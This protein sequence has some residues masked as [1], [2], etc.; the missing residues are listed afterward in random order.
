MLRSEELAKAI[1]TLKQKIA[2]K[3]NDLSRFKKDEWRTRSD[4]H[5]SEAVLCLE[6]ILESTEMLSN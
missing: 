5:R 4:E 6:P 2:K 1:L 3:G